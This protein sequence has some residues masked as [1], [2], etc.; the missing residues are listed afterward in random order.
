[1]QK[2]PPSAKRGGIKTLFNRCNRQH[3][4]NRLKHRNIFFSAGQDVYCSSV[5][6]APDKP[7]DS[8]AE[9]EEHVWHVDFPERIFRAFTLGI[10][11]RIM[12]R[13]RE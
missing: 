5:L 9:P 13:E 1:M 3:S 2:A 7:A 4:F 10:K 8:L 6:M 12:R 11:H